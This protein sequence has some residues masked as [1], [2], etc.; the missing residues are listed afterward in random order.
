MGDYTNPAI[1]DEENLKNCSKLLKTAE[2]KQ[3]DFTHIKPY[4]NNFY[5]L[6]PPYHKTYS[7][8]NGNGFGDTEHGNGNGFGDTEHGRLAK[9]C[10]SIDKADSYFMVSNSDTPFVR[11]LYKKYHIEKVSASRSVSCKAHQRGK[12]TELI[13]RNYK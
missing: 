5:Y 13:I 3:H 1:V 10:A 8:Y 6:D 9:F 12:E 7:Q 4:K 2:V 11:K